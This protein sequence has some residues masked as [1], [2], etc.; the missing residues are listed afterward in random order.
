MDAENV[1]IAI[2]NAHIRLIALNFQSWKPDVE[3]WLHSVEAEESLQQ[4]LAHVP[5]SPT[6]H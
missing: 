4:L 2:I 5:C 1:P 6:L 3:K